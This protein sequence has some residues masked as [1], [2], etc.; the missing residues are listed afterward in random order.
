M[1][2]HSMTAVMLMNITKKNTQFNFL[3]NP[4]PWGGLREAF[5]EKI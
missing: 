3:K 5:D 4:L 2:F 1:T